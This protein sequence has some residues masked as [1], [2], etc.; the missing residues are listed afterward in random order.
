MYENY[1]TVAMVDLPNGEGQLELRV[2]HSHTLKGNDNVRLSWCH[3]MH[4]P[5]CHVPMRY[6]ELPGK[7]V[8]FCQISCGLRVELPADAQTVGQLKAHFSNISNI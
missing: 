3:A 6:T 5:G 2:D 4:R 8:L 1:V 7:V